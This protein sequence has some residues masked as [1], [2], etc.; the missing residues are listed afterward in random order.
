MEDRIKELEKK[1]IEAIDH[2]SMRHS[3]ERQQIKRDSQ[4]R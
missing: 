2:L 1:S 3:Q 4:V